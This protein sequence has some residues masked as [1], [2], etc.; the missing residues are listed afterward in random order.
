MP[1][2]MNNTYEE[3]NVEDNGSGDS[4]IKGRVITGVVCGAVVGAVVKGTQF[5]KAKRKE[6]RVK[7]FEGIPVVDLRKNSVSDCSEETQE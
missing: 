2:D 1:E 3:V 5:I 4:K 6:K 7:E